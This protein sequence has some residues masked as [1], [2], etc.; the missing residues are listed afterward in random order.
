M[1]YPSYEEWFDAL[2]PR[3]K[4]RATRLA[5][6][7]RE[8]GAPDPESWARSEISEDKPQFARFL[9][10]RSIWPD[11]IDRWAREPDRWILK[12][13]E[14]AAGRPNGLFADAGLAMAR[15]LDRGVSF[16]DIAS[17]ARLVAYSTAFGV[18][19]HIDEGCDEAVSDDAPGWCLVE[20]SA[21][22]R[23]TGREIGG[24]HESILMMD[25]SGREGRPR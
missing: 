14:E 4:E 23:P 2:P 10:L 15:M 20:T 22:G 21:K 3:K 17:V 24:L 13:V 5:A 16:T 9:V 12:A 11:E 6:A 19:Q 25:P 1:S 18:L 7:F 8:F